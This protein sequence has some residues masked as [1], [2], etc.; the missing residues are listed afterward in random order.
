MTRPLRRRGTPRSGGRSR[1]AEAPLWQR[2]NGSSSPPAPCSFSPAPWFRRREMV[3]RTATRGRAWPHG[4]R[5]ASAVQ[6][7]RGPRDW[8]QV[9]AGQQPAPL[10]LREDERRA[11]LTAHVVALELSRL[12]LAA[13]GHRR[14]AVEA[15]RDFLEGEGV[16]GEAP[17]VPPKPSIFSEHEAER[18]DADEVVG[19][20]LAEEGDVLSLLGVGPFAD[21]LLELSHGLFHWS[22]SFTLGL[23][24]DR[25]VVCYPRVSF[26]P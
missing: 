15:R 14:A 5:G 18:A 19:K 11:E 1:C 22:L 7:R 23:F 26:S 4:G 21:E 25:G 8:A 13:R 16:V 6:E 9:K 2:Q 10:L 3:P 17:L 24:S 20:G 12:R